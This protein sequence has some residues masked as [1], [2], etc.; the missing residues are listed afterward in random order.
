MPIE[1]GITEE[2]A[3]QKFANSEIIY[4]IHT[5]KR[6]FPT[7]QNNNNQIQLY[8]TTPT[9]TFVMRRSDDE[10]DL[11]LHR[12]FSKTGAATHIYESAPKRSEKG[13]RTA[14]VYSFIILNIY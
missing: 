14:I 11:I 4:K 6:V 12:T 7:P 10:E 1:P 2:F 8:P 13:N 9:L 5:L 3:R